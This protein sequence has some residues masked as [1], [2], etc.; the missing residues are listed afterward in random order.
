M[1]AEAGQGNQPNV[2]YLAQVR[3]VQLV[4]SLQSAPMEIVEPG[5]QA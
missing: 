2:E 5:A 4:D 3:P 1:N